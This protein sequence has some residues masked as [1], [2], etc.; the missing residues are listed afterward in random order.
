M[1]VV[2]SIGRVTL[3]AIFAVSIWREVTVTLG[4]DGSWW[5]RD[6]IPQYHLTTSFSLI[7][8]ITRNQSIISTFEIRSQRVYIMN[9]KYPFLCYISRNPLQCI[10]SSR[11]LD[12]QN[13]RQCTQYPLHGNQKPIYCFFIIAWNKH[14]ADQRAVNYKSRA[15]ARSWI[16]NEMTGSAFK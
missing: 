14:S 4:S 10:R 9:W 11:Q 12:E 16:V 2:H 5:F 13:A 15:K 3:K 7:N 1:R 8:V 6:C